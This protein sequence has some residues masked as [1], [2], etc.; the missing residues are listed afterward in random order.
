MGVWT[1]S[2]EEEIGTGG[3]GFKRVIMS[4]QIPKK[5]AI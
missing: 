4:D 3:G 2:Q 1:G 5:E